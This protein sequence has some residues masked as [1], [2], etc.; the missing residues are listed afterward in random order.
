MTFRHESLGN[1]GIA[2][3]LRDADDA[4]AI[5][6]PLSNK[7]QFLCKF[8]TDLS[9]MGKVD[10]GYD[11]EDDHFAVSEEQLLYVL[12]QY[13]EYDTRGRRGAAGTL[14]FVTCEDHV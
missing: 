14:L 9:E 7:E 6:M 5:C 2:P 13:S 1:L 4:V 12:H 3:S 11:S 10:V 8:E